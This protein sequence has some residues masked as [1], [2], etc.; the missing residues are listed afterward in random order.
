MNGDQPKP[1]LLG[2]AWGRKTLGQWLEARGRRSVAPRYDCSKSWALQRHWTVPRTALL[3]FH[4]PA[5]IHP[6][7][8]LYSLPSIFFAC[9]LVWFWGPS[10]NFSESN[11]CLAK[12]DGGLGQGFAGLS[13][14][15]VQLLGYWLQNLGQAANR[16]RRPF[17]FCKMELRLFHSQ[18]R[19]LNGLRQSI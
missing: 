6:N 17:P 15:S 7:L 5:F 9:Y 13:S 2:A 10:F 4:E 18:L 1:S 11:F 19:G 12:C 3:N 16:P 14:S 8:S